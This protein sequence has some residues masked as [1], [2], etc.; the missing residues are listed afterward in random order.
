MAEY[1]SGNWNGALAAFGR[2]MKRAKQVYVTTGPSSPCVTGSSATKNSPESGSGFVQTWTRFDQVSDVDLLRFP[3]EAME[4]MYA[5][6][7]T[8]MD[9][10][11]EIPGRVAVVAK[12]PQDPSTYYFRGGALSQSG[13]C[14]VADDDFAT[15]KR[16][17]SI[18]PMHGGQWMRS[19]DCIA[20]TLSA[21]PGFGVSP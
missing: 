7:T 5:P 2:S 18:F 14:R 6:E 13:F 10:K 4:L 17:E 8:I 12:D 9:E 11:S 15:L 1:R 3:T 16:P 21:S 20:T 19:F